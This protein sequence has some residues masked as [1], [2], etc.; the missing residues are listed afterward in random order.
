MLLN[1]CTEQIKQGLDVEVISIG[2][3][4]QQE[5]PLETKLKQ[6]NI[7]CIPWRMMALPDLRES[8]KILRYCRA[9]NTSVIHSHG[10]KG[11]IL[12][13]MI[14]KFMRGIPVITTI[15][16]YTRHK[17]FRKMTIYQWIDKQCLKKLDAVVLVSPAMEHQIPAKSLANRL[18]I[19]P[20]GIPEATDNISCSELS[21]PSHFNDSDFKIGSI[22]RLSGEKNF[23]LLVRAMPIILQSI[24]NAKLVIHGDGSERKKLETLIDQLDLSS[25]IFLPGYV[26]QPSCFYET[27][28]VYVNCSLTEGMPISILEAMRSGCPIVAAK[29]PAN[30]ALLGHIN[31]LGQL[32]ELNTNSLAQSIIRL[33]RANSDLK[34]KQKE[35][36][37]AEFSTHYTVQKM[38]RCYHE[39]YDE[40]REALSQ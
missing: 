15:H 25:N 10:Y 8:F 11:N 32:C 18:H 1:L 13:G 16:G 26:E 29:I 35:V 24:P 7:N 12:L 5:K 30:I 4:N 14:P 19:I 39:I 33:Y 23:Q 27:L 2:T 6:E 36:C 9:S 21:G 31:N 28:D 22:G 34:K 40:Y 3:P 20:N 38:A 17:K 37:K